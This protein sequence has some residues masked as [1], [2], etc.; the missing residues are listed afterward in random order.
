MEDNTTIEKYR[1]S[2]FSSNWFRTIPVSLFQK[3]FVILTS[4]PHTLPLHGSTGDIIFLSFFDY[5]SDCVFC[6]NPV[7]LRISKLPLDLE[8]ELI[9]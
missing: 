3:I 5:S 2:P 4:T 7:Y 8:I 1:H 9:I 6:F